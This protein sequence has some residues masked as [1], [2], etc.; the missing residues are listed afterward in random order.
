M[1][2]L[3]EIF[4]IWYGVNLEMINCE[5]DSSG[6][7]FVSRTSSNNGIVGHVRALDYIEPNPKHTISVA[8]SGSVLSSFY[9][10]YAY[11]SGRDVYVLKPKQ[12]LSTPEMI[13]YCAAIEKNKYRYSYGR[14]A[15]KTLKD[16]F[17]PAIDK[18]PDNIKEI[19]FKVNDYMEKASLLEKKY[20]L[21]VAEWKVFNMKSIF[22]IKLGNPLHKNTIDLS[23][24]GIKYVTRTT[25]HNGVEAYIQE[26]Y[27]DNLNNG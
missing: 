22:N 25:N 21:N 19:N 1:K 12:I 6:I 4:D 7:P 18:I 26:S 5:E 11:Y 27:D 20:F 10:P 16:I 2:R 15:N 17:I 14:Q 9:H 13:F 24:S 8:C 3:D 23:S